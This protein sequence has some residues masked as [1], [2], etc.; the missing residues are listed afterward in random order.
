MTNLSSFIYLA[1]PR[2]VLR[3]Q[4]RNMR[5]IF[6]GISPGFA[7]LRLGTAAATTLLPAT[8]DL[9]AL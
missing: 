4:A 8:A 3:A 1:E 9:D 5:Y 2:T 6:C 7:G